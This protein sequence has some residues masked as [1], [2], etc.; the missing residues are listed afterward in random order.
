MKAAIPSS[1]QQS[2]FS[3]ILCQSLSL[4]NRSQRRTRR[5]TKPWTAFKPSV[6]CEQLGPA[7]DG[8]LD[9]WITVEDAWLRLA[10]TCPVTVMHQCGQF[11]LV[12]ANFKS[13]DRHERH[14]ELLASIVD[15]NFYRWHFNGHSGNLVQFIDYLGKDLVLAI[16][17]LKTIQRWTDGE[18]LA[19]QVRSLLL[20]LQ[21]RR[22]P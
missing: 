3:A 4:P 19:G 11:E 18:D 12:F 6:N 9:I 8:P 17:D 10:R 16:T 14:Q 21:G 13:V 2:D 15:L 20:R 22:A 5:C 1:D 7:E